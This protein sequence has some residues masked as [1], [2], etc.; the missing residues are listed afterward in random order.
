VCC[1]KKRTWS[2]KQLL[3]WRIHCCHSFLNKQNYQF[4]IRYCS[5]NWVKLIYAQLRCS[6]NRFNKSK[7]TI[8]IGGGANNLSI[9]WHRFSDNF[10]FICFCGIILK[11]IQSTT[12]LA[13]ESP[14]SKIW[15]YLTSKRTK[16]SL[17]LNAKFL[18]SNSVCIDTLRNGFFN[19]FNNSNNI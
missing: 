14:F 9:K 11:I 17:F 4:W 6:L 13:C 7:E 3:T 2:L 1:R 8:K 10:F 15:E 19:I 18:R 16:S 5:G 12:E